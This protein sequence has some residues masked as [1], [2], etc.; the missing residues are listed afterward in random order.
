MKP[1]GTTSRHAS[2]PHALLLAAAILSASAAYSQQPDASKVAPAQ[3]APDQNAP[4][5][6]TPAPDQTA[7]PAPGKA[8]PDRTPE[9]TTEGHPTENTVAENKAHAWKMLHD[10]AQSSKPDMRIQAVGALA[11]M[12]A[13]VEA[14]KLVRQEL[15]DSDRD[16]RLA[17]VL[18]IQSMKERTMV[19]DLRKALDDSAPEVS[20]AAA[21]ALWNL[22]DES[23][24]DVLFDVLDGERKASPSFISSNLHTANKDLHSPTTLATIGAKQGAYMLL[25]PFGVGLDALEY[26]RKGTTGNSARVLAVNL[27]SQKKNNTTRDQLL[28]ALND[29]DPFVR[30]AAAHALGDYH[31]KIVSDSLL[32]GF[33]DS[34]TSVSLVSAASY[35]R[36]TTRSDNRTSSS[37][38]GH[39]AKNPSGQ[40][41]SNAATP[42]GA[43]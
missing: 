36:A 18:A 43:H 14:E 16:V 1:L 7:T 34:K 17:A 28:G 19:P 25:G 22:G 27:L 15:A 42:K 3:V 41:S 24:K 4:Q 20:F 30:T 13:S 37:A 32:S 2:V 29:K 38:G 23:G 31:T 9:T 26:I 33:D 21:T 11:T 8:T 10:A 35:I 39:A 5:T 40:A 6:Q 12:H